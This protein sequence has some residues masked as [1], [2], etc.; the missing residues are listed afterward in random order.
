MAKKSEI[1]DIVWAMKIVDFAQCKDRKRDKIVGFKVE[2]NRVVATDNHRIALQ[3][4][5]ELIPEATC[6]RYDE[7]CVSIDNMGKFADIKAVLPKGKP[8]ITFTLQGKGDWLTALNG[9]AKMHRQPYGT[10]ESDGEK[11]IVTLSTMSPSMEAK[12]EIPCELDPL[13]PFKIGIDLMYLWEA[14]DAAYRSDIRSRPGISIYAVDAAIKINTD[15]GF[16]C[17]T[18]PTRED[19]AFVT[20]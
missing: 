17:L 8:A 3:E 1:P 19:G 15:Y 4:V 9:I 14:L 10:L 13:K 18:M 6:G 16:M 2:P 12:L 20:R 11:V 5:S 7:K